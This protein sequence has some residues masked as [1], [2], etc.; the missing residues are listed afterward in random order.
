VAHIRRLPSG[1]FNAVVRLPNGKRKSITRPLKGEVKQLATELEAQIARGAYGVRNDHKLTFAAWHARW[2]QAR[3]LARTTAH[4]QDLRLAK[5]VLPRWGAWPLASIGRIDVQQWVTDLGR[6]RGAHVAFGCYAVFSKMLADA[7]LEGLIPTTPCRKII[8]P[9][10]EKPAPRWLTEEE[11]GRLLLAFDEGE[12]GRPVP[13][14]AQWKAMVA[15]ACHSGLRSGELAGLDVGKVDFE[16]GLIRVDQVMTKFGLRSY[17]KSDS[18]RRSA[19]VHQDALDLLW[20][21]VADKPASA[22]V[23]PAPRGGRLDQSNFLKTVWHPALERAGIEPVRAYVTRHTFAS[24]MIQ[25]G[26]PEWDIAQALGHRTTEFVHRYAFLKPDA[27]ESIR[28]AWSRARDAHATHGSGDGSA[29]SG[30]T[31]GQRDMERSFYEDH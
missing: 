6:Q 11:Y 2:V 14:G 30:E 15:V 27:H 26:V 8:L 24:W 29:G 16:R 4:E 3:N 19:P 9:K 25:A 5:Y 28:A 17:P 21:V 13:Q 20:P 1:N 22:P 31:A 7:E 10:K 12:D 23:F 18:S